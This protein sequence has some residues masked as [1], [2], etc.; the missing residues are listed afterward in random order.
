MREPFDNRPRVKIESIEEFL[1]KQEQEQKKE[2]P[3]EP[4]KGIKERLINYFGTFGIYLYFAFTLFLAAFPFIMIDSN[5][6]VTVLL[7]FVN[8]LI[9]FASVIFWAWGLIC[10]INGPQDIFAIIYYIIFVIAWVPYYISVLL[11]VLGTLFEKNV[12]RKEHQNEKL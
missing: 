4:R 9:P 7:A 2:E 12:K 5:F 8:L 3:K 10:A 11:S 6:F 1:K